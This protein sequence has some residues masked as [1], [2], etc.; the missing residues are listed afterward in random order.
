MEPA[1][2]RR[3]HSPDASGYCPAFVPPQWSPPVTDGN[4][5]NAWTEAARER[6]PQWSPPVTG[7]NTRQLRGPGRRRQGAAM[8]PASDRREHGSENPGRLTC[9]DRS[10]RERPVYARR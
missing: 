6:M 9:A 10:S 4:T 2:D 5:L 1:G 8:E 3:E 7:G